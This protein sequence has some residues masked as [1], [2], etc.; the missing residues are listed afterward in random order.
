MLKYL[1]SIRIWTLLGSLLTVCPVEARPA[2]YLGS[3]DNF[4]LDQPRVAVEVYQTNPIHSF[5]PD[6]FNWFVLDT[7]ANGLMAGG[8]ATQEMTDNGYQVVA[9]Y[10]EYGVVGDEIFDVSDE[11]YMDFSGTSGIRNTLADVRLLSHPTIY[12]NFD[13]IVGM[14]AMVNRVVEWDFHAMLTDVYMGTDFLTE[15]PAATLYPR[16]SVPLE[17]VEFEQDGQQNPDDPLPTWAP[18]PFVKTKV[19]REQ[20][21][22]T[23]SFLLDSGA[24]LSILS[25]PTAI[26]LGLDTNRNGI[27][28][29]DTEAIGSIEIGGIGG[30]KEVPIVEIDSLAIPTNQGIDLVW[31]DLQCVVVDIANIPGILGMDILTSGWIEAVFGEPDEF[32]DGYI[33]KMYLDFRNAKNLDGMMYIDINPDL[34]VARLVDP[35]DG[36]SYDL[37]DFAFFADRWL[38]DDC[39][40][41]SDPNWC[42][43]ADFDRNGIVNGVDLMVLLEYWQATPAHIPLSY[44]MP[45]FAV[46]ADQ[47]QRNNCRPYNWCNNADINHDQKVN[48]ADLAEFTGRWLEQLPP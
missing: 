1:R 39:A 34:D 46:F 30:T 16:Y 9:E 45:G 32:P 48:L 19:A 26:G 44:D 38:R 12:L 7:G 2:I 17:L 25:T 5:G 20:Y 18:L 40:D 15:V 42:C 24:Q 22:A 33:E 41:S 29:I 4:P 43:G 3:S 35:N 8:L 28:D 21:W 11:Y 23:G 37:F 27:I 14:P 36:A 6:W 47:W 31:Q 13:G 10:L